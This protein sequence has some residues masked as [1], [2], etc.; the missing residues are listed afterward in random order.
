MAEHTPGPWQVIY[1][2]IY[3]VENAYPIAVLSR[4]LRDGPEIDANA[5]LIAAAPDLL[6][7]LE[8]LVYQLAGHEPQWEDA[9]AAVAKAKGE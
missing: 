8:D 6:E 1:P 3:D 7:V 9:R 2:G 5:R 4:K